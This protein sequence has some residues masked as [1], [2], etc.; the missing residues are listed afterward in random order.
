MIRLFF[1][2]TVSPSSRKQTLSVNGANATESDPKKVELSLIPIAR[3][4]P[5]FEPTNKLNFLKII[6]SAKA[7]SNKP[8]V[9]FTANSG[10]LLFSSLFNKCEITSL[11]VSD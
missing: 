7:P 4:L 2:K 5:F 10:G 11:S 1:I 6:A 3:G 8:K 9:F